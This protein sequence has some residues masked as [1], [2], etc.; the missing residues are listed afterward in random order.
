MSGVISQHELTGATFSSAVHH[1][2]AVVTT[3]QSDGGHV[4]TLAKDPN[5]LRAFAA[6]LAEAA[7]KLDAALMNHTAVA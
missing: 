4:A 5:Q 2:T 1:E 6:A 7:D 3:W